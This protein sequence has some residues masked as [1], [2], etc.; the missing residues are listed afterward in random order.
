YNYRKYSLVKLAFEYFIFMER[1]DEQVEDKDYKALVSEL[2]FVIKEG[3]LNNK[4]QDKFIEDVHNIREKIAKKLEVLTIYADELEVYEY[5]INRLEYKFTLIENDNI[6]E[7]F[8]QDLFD[9]IKLLKDDNTRL[10]TLIKE[11]LA[12]LPMRLTRGKFYEYLTNSLYMYKG[13]KK[14]FLISFIEILRNIYAPEKFE[15]Y[16][17]EFPNISDN[18]EFL[19]NVSY[20]NLTINE[21]DTVLLKLTNVNKEVTKHLDSYVDLIILTNL[22]YASIISK[23]EVEDKIID[24]AKKIISELQ[25]NHDTE[26]TS[27]LFDELQEIE[28][29]QEEVGRKILTNESFIDSTYN[30][31]ISVLK[32]IGL[33][34]DYFKFKHLSK[35]TS[36]S[37]YAE[38]GEVKEKTKDEVILDDA[39]ISKCIEE[40]VA[41]LDDEIKKDSIIVRRAKLSKILGTLPVSFKNL[42]EIYNYVKFSL[43]QCGNPSEQKISMELIGEIIKEYE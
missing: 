14:E 28:G 40:F 20:N 10:N 19:K 21:Y 17:V 13:N 18:I 6:V 12:Q 36:S 38:I 27:G 4:D 9:S 34:E 5:I 3:V 41:F 35:L 15:G 32:N 2:N 16:G 11:V 43:E 33:E 29:V 24:T 39:E 1:L 8:I 42:E 31:Y 26:T 30:K 23:V 7:E 22:V 25:Q 37:L